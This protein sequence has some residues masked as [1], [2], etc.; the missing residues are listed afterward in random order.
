MAKQKTNHS[1]AKQGNQ[2]IFQVSHEVDDNLLPNPEELQKY[3]IIDPSLI[4][5]IKA[6]CDK[7]Q[8]ARIDFNNQKIKIN[9][10][11]NNK[12]FAIDMT[13]IIVSVIVVLAGMAMSSYLIHLKHVLTGTIFGGS[14]IVFY[15]VRVLNFRKNQNNN[16]DKEQ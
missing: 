8:N 2:Q 5:W 15:A 11:L 3:Q 12:F 4:N 9:K 16:K 10:S 6:R 7:E 13:S 14:V 1:V